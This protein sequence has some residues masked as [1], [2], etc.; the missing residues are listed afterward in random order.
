MSITLSG[1][2]S[3]NLP[4]CTTALSFEANSNNGIIPSVKLFDAV[5]HGVHRH[6]GFVETQLSLPS[7]KPWLHYFSISDS[8]Y[9]ICRNSQHCI[10]KNIDMQVHVP[11][12]PEVEEEACLA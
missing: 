7:P 4:I 11:G 9:C 12:K 6:T 5:H 8:V 1:I 2:M 3:F 10:L